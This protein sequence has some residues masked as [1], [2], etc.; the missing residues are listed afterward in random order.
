MPSRTTKALQIGAAIIYYSD[1]LSTLR[2]WFV[3][4]MLNGNEKRATKLKEDLF[5][6]AIDGEDATLKIV[7]ASG[8]L[9]ILFTLSIKVEPVI[10]KEK[11]RGSQEED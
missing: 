9:A 8:K 11:N 1:L 5:K 7:D 6:K 3:A 10:E 4:H 2:E